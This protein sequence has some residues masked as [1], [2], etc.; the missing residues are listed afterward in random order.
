MRTTPVTGPSVWKG[1]KLAQKQDWVISL[2]QA[3]IDE[4]MRASQDPNVLK[5][6]LSE[7][8]REDFPLPVLSEKLRHAHSQLEGG[9]GFAVLRGLPVR[10]LSLESA[11]RAIWGLACHL[12]YPEPQDRAGSIIHSVRNTG[13]KVEGSES[14][15]G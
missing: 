5:R 15:R 1:S 8:K 7:L 9:R 12:G 10:Q 13:Q 14:E 2:A 11:Q 6:P 3:E 4:V